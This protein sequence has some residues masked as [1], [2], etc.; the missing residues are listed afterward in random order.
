MCHLCPQRSSRF[1]CW[2]QWSLMPSLLTI[3]AESSR[4]YP[5]DCL[6]CPTIVTYQTMWQFINIKH[7]KN[8][9]KNW[10]TLHPKKI[11]HI[12]ITGPPIV[13]ATCPTCVTCVLKGV[14][15]LACGIDVVI[16]SSMLT[17]VSKYQINMKSKLI[18]FIN[19]F[20]DMLVLLWLHTSVLLCLPLGPP[21]VVPNKFIF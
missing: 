21:L 1:R 13:I 12:Y 18:L 15:Y 9:L 19:I 2:H 8:V 14:Q 20:I 3:V 17:V 4:K 10:Y 5:Y 11:N 7:M 6:C 16:L